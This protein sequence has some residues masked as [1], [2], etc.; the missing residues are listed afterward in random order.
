MPFCL[1]LFVI[2]FLYC[3]NVWA[4]VLFTLEIYACWYERTYARAH[5]HVH[6]HVCIT[7]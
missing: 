1:L 5:M 6:V 7:Y 2:M 4:L 3:F